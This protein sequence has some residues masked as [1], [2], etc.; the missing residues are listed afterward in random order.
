MDV[1]TAPPSYKVAAATL[2]GTKSLADAAFAMATAPGGD[3][4]TKRRQL[5][6]FGLAGDRLFDR[7]ERFQ[8]RM[9]ALR[10]SKPEGR[11]EYSGFTTAEL[12][13]LVAEKARR[14]VPPTDDEI[15]AMVMSEPQLRR[16]VEDAIVAGDEV[17]RDALFNRLAESIEP[18][19]DDGDDDLVDRSA[20]RR[21]QRAVTSRARFLS[22]LRAKGVRI[23]AQD[24]RL[25][26][27]PKRAVTKAE[28]QRLVSDRVGLTT[29]LRKRRAR[30]QRPG[31]RAAEPV[32]W[33]AE[34][35]AR[36]QAA[37][38][39]IVSME[40]P[41]T[42]IDWGSIPPWRWN[43]R[44]VLASLLKAMNGDR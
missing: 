39:S 36:R 4:T 31:V 6:A 9:A 26:V 24:G 20:R 5:E 40:P 2:A 1:D 7:F 42:G 27:S 18:L 16:K 29:L 8:Q 10:V 33:S 21:G 14:L 32:K 13:T 30:V 15:V 3:G 37:D 44:R 28:R 35:M 11:S 34:W 43:D 19:T 12:R 22:T 25:I 41:S 17:L 38:P 23:W